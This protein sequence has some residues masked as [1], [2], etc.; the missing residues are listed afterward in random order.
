[1]VKTAFLQSERRG[2]RGLRR[3][4][5]EAILA[6]RLEREI[7]KDAV[8]ED[9]LNTVY[10]GDVDG[11][12]IV[13]IQ[14]A[15]NFYFAKNAKELN[16]YECA[17]LVGSLASPNTRNFKA[18]PGAAH[19]YALKV[20][21][22]AVAHNFVS[23]R[24][25]E[26]SV[27]TRS[28]SGHVEFAQADGRHFLSALADEA[29]RL[30][31]ANNDAEVRLVVTIDPRQQLLGENLVCRMIKSPGNADLQGALVTM[32]PLGEIRALVGG[33]DFATS[34]FNRA[35]QAKRQPGSA[36][37]PFVYASAM[38]AGLSPATIRNDLPLN[39]D[40]WQ[41][42]NSDRRYRGP[43]SL[44]AAFAYSV[45]TV[46]V[47]VAQEVG[48]PAVIRVAHAFGISS[49]IKPN[50]TIALGTS[51]VTL[52]ELTRAFVPFVNEGRRVEAHSITVAI[53]AGRVI[54]Q[55]PSGNGAIVLNRHA[56]AEMRE[57]LGAVVKFGTGKRA[58]PNAVGGKTG[59]SQGARDGWFVGWRQADSLLTG[60][61]VGNDAN[62]PVPGLSGGGLPA[63]LWRQFSA[64][65]PHDPGVNLAPPI[66]RNTKKLV[67][68]EPSVTSMPGCQR[69]PNLC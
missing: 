17:V 37:K 28:K 34:S 3:K 55:S 52:L 44:G 40:G 47:R 50:L 23:P 26:A 61:W 57:L 12:T 41:P 35:T 13:G 6:A 63:E 27:R 60:I 30:N 2:L 29:F 68:S 53:S 8:I 69:F 48:V 10:F 1:L 15:A 7:S 31:L 51:E 16:L 42:E 32:T 19:R 49:N 56:H 22:K 64:A 5:R 25:A 46:A 24:E 59:T 58:G 4:L 45:N 9:Y 43:M 21:A 36:F 11:T 38:Q 67:S 14:Q 54:F 33:C 18:H 20:V 66:Q 65:A 39:V 62:D